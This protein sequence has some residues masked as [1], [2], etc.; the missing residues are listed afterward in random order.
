MGG[1]GG[2]GEFDMYTLYCGSLVKQPLA[3]V[4]CDTVQKLVQHA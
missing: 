4:P 1:G 2:G 3:L